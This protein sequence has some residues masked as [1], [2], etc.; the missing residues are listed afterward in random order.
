MKQ[1]TITF[2]AFLRQYVQCFENFP[3]LASCANAMNWKSRTSARNQINKLIE[4][5]LVERIDD[6]FGST[7]CRLIEPKKR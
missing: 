2:L 1:R 5:G 7:I 3:T 4:K 6:G